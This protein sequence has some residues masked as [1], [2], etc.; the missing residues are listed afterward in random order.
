LR[1]NSKVERRN[2]EGALHRTET[3][4]CALREHSLEKEENE[5]KILRGIG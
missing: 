5:E 3:I 4:P 2:I 1:Y